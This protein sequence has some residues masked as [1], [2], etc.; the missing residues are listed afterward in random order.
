MISIINKQKCSGCKACAN[1]CPVDAIS[2]ELDR[3]GFWYPIVNSEKCINCGKCEKV[4][5]YNKKEHGIPA[6]NNEYEAIFFAA[7]LKKQSELKTVSSGGAFQAVAETVLN[8][9]GII[10]G[11]IQ[12]N[13]DHIYHIRVSDFEKLKLT[14]RSKYLHSDIG[15]SEINQKGGVKT[16][17]R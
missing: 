14:R 9:N 13:V 1:A 15:S 17:I 3:E 16:S 4:C 12:E 5:P 11:A 7:Q 2:F 10:Y 6:V 8:K